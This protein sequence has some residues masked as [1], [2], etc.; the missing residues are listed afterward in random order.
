MNGWQEPKDGKRVYLITDNTRMDAF[1][2]CLKE[3]DKDRLLVSYGESRM[4]LG[5]HY[6]RKDLYS[7]NLVG[8]C[9][10][11]TSDGENLYDSDGNELLIKVIPRFHVTVVHLLNYIREDDEFDRYMAP[12][13]SSSRQKEKEIEAIDR[14]E[15]F[16]FFEN[17]KPLKVEDSIFAENSIMT[18][19]VFLTLLRLLCKRPLMG[20]MIKDEK[21]LTGKVKGKVVIA[22][23]IRA[24]TMHGRND[25][26]YCQYLRYT[27]DIVENQILKAALKKAKRF[28][29][30]YFGDYSKEHNSYVDM[31]SYCS[32]VLGHISDI[33]CSG[34]ACAGLRFSGCYVYYQPVMTMAKMILDDI[35]IESN[36]KVNTTGYIVPYAVS[37]EKLFEVYVRAYLKKNGIYSYKRKDGKG[38]RLEKFDEK[39]KVFLEEDAL[40]NP[41]KYI[42][43]S[44]KPDLIL[45]NQKTGETVVM[46][47]KYKE[48][49]SGNAR[50]DRL[51]LLAYSMMLNAN[52]V[53]IIFPTQ[54]EVVIFD[55]HRINS[56]ESRVVQYHQMLLGVMEDHPF[57]ADY[58]KEK[59]FEK[60]EIL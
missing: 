40:P 24:N 21:N 34:S 11:K 49:T 13:T 54:T 7:S 17:E 48:Y 27:D 4:N 46:D 8:I 12:Q 45:T 37:M 25:R 1:T 18:V 58:I 23:N 30:D 38:I 43:G 22:K 19:T 36:G 39:R 57:L 29:I 60:K 32:N 15:I 47:V 51:Q 2:D 33:S 5:I 16:Y 53:G 59:V 42:S 50:N 9:R 3:G 10:L 44:I 26:F 35:S 55:A 6:Y 14:N 28:I 52:H 56:M 41:G 20:R 31:I